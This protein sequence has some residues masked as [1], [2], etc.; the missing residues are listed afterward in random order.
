[1]R[2]INTAEELHGILLDLGKEFH[3]ICVKNNIPYYMLGGTMLGAVRHKG[4]IPWDDDMDFGVP[5]EYYNKCIS[6]LKKELSGK[7]KVLTIDNTDSLL[8]DFIKISDDRTEIAEN[9]KEN[10]SKIG[11]NI[12]I[13][14]L[15]L[16]EEI[17]FKSRLIRLLICLQGYIFLSVKSRPFIKKLIA[18]TLKFIFFFLKKKTIINFINNCYSHNKGKYIVN[19]YGAWGIK[20]I[21]KNEIIGTP[22]LYAFED[23]TFYGVE[24]YTVYLS[25][26]YGN[27]MELPSETERHLHIK[28]C[29]WK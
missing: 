8:F 14:P 5:R 28:N 1:M 23:T 19:I 17:G 27:Y 13:F 7:Y 11:V 2:K 16:I 21:M 26:L 20:E 10:L 24:N 4:F 12:D 6:I 22:I 18:L 9:Y 29:Y 25:N 3:K 15:D